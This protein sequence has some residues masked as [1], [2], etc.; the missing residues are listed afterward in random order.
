M[1]TSSSQRATPSSIW[2]AQ[3]WPAKCKTCGFRSCGTA[4]KG[5]GFRAA[6]STTA[7]SIARFIPHPRAPSRSVRAAKAGT[8]FLAF[9]G[10]LAPWPASGPGLQPARRSSR[11]SFLPRQRLVSFRTL[12][13]A[14]H[15]HTTA[16][17]RPCAHGPR[18]PASPLTWVRPRRAAGCL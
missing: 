7:A 2:R 15:P 8:A 9:A 6:T 1:D 16:R 18:P 13:P 14:P 17:L 3:W 4:R 11:G 10:R 12:M 5:R